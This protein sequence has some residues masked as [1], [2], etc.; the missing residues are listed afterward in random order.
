MYARNLFSC[1]RSLR[2]VF[3]VSGCSLL[4]TC[5]L[6]LGLFIVIGLL[7][8][9]LRL[10]GRLRDVLIGYF[11]VLPS[12]VDLLLVLGLKVVIAIEVGGILSG[13]LDVGEYFGSDATPVPPLTAKIWVKMGGRH[14]GRCTD[15]A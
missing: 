9:A 1:T 14:R 3:A 11:T 10:L 13:A 2:L 15:K 6:S 7:V 5:F 8:I 12:L 4:G